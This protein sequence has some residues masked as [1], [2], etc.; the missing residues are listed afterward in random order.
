MANTVQAAPAAGR[1]SDTYRWMQLVIGVLA[2]VMIA[3]YQY[4]WTFFVPDI[5]KKF[6]WSRTE[7]Q[8]A[9]TL[10]V[11]FETWL[12]PVEGWFVDKYGPRLVVLFGGMVGASATWISIP[13]TGI[14]DYSDTALKAAYQK[15]ATIPSRGPFLEVSPMPGQDLVGPHHL[16][17][18]GV[19]R[20]RSNSGSD[21]LP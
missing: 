14:A 1:V 5:E 17:R 18:A 10:F 7:I 9:F 19:Y 13:G 16:A 4:G 15:R 8:W 12:V 21:S 2:M 11:L 3:N 20:Q 6:G